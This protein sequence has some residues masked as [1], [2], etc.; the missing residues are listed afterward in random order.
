MGI[1]CCAML[2]LRRNTI[3]EL[4]LLSILLTIN[5]FRFFFLCVNHSDS[6]FSF[7]DAAIVCDKNNL[8]RTV[9]WA[10]WF[11]D[12]IYV[13]SWPSGKLP[14]AILLKNVNFCQFFWQKCQ[15]QPLTES[16]TLTSRHTRRRW[17]VT[18]WRHTL[19]RGI[20]DWPFTVRCLI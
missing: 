5:F 2:I 11:Y 9:D 8:N 10:L 19:P 7:L 14:M 6:P 4:H 15:V 3:G 13:C 17:T 20:V 18:W 16:K 12:K 1:S